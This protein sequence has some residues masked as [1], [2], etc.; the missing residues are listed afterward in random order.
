LER[1]SEIKILRLFHL[2]LFTN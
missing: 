1:H 2:N